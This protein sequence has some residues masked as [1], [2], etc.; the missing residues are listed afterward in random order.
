MASILHQLQGTF[1]STALEAFDSPIG[2]RYSV[3]TSNSL[4]RDIANAGLSITS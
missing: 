2:K 4:A 1:A 3:F